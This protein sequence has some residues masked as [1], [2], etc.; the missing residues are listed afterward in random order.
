MKYIIF[1]DVH[2][3]YQAIQA[4][5]EYVRKALTTEEYQYWC[6]GDVI[7]YGPNPGLV[8]RWVKENVADCW[9]IG[10]HDSW[11]KTSFKAS[12]SAMGTLS[13]QVACLRQDNELLLAWATG[14]VKEKLKKEIEAIQSSDNWNEG[15]CSIV[16]NNVKWFFTHAAA[17]PQR[18]RRVAYLWPWQSSLEMH[19]QYLHEYLLNNQFSHV[20]L[21]VGHTHLPIITRFEAGKP[22]FLSIKYEQSMPLDK[23]A[24][25][26]NPGSLGQPRDGDPRASFVIYDPDEITI[27][28]IRLEYDIQETISN[29][30]DTKLTEKMIRNLV[31]RLETGNGFD[32]EMRYAEIYQRPKWDLRVIHHNEEKNRHL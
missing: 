19:L 6:L 26:I 4:M 3:N 28:F 1:S 11:L 32:K 2:A 23:G 17:F 14:F 25:V 29:L 9:I 15:L 20:G 13:S 18:A 16:E 31:K 21:F 10:N 8:L 24:W 22:Q 7:G 27:T 5:D 30:W 12:D